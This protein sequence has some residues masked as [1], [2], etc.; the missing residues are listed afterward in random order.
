M[1]PGKEGLGGKMDRANRAGAAGDAWR[2][3]ATLN[4]FA[5]ARFDGIFHRE[6]RRK[7]GQ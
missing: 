7:P 4:G 3:V 5:A 1:V 2:V 6:Q